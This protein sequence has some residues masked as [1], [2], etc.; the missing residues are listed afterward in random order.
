MFRGN[1]QEMFARCGYGWSGGSRSARSSNSSLARRKRGG[2][3]TREDTSHQHG[4]GFTMLTGPQT[5]LMT[6]KILTQ[7]TGEKTTSF[8]LQLFLKYVSMLRN[9]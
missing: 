8:F 3:H 7:V 1:L 4:R 2:A 9:L 5:P 6:V